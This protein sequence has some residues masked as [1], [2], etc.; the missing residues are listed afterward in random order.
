MLRHTFQGTAEQGCLFGKRSYRRF[1]KY[2]KVPESDFKYLLHKWKRFFCLTVK[3]TN[4]FIMALH[5]KPSVVW[6]HGSSAQG[7]FG[8]TGPFVWVAVKR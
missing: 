5:T 6:L 8:R 1:A 2:C 3:F 4:S 7:A